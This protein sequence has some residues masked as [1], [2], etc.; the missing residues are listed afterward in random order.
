MRA[1]N[2][3]RALAAEDRFKEGWPL[4]GNPRLGA[5]IPYFGQTLEYQ[6]QTGNGVED[7]T[8][9]IRNFGWAVCFGVV[10]DQV[11]TLCQWKPG[12]N[13]ASWELPPGGIGKIGPEDTLED[14]TEQTKRSYLKETGLGGGNF[15]HL[16]H[17]M[18]ETGKYR[19][20]GP[21]DHGLQ[22]HLFLGTGLERAQGARTP[23]PNEIMETIMVPLEQFPEVLVSGLFMEESAVVCAYKALIELGL[24]KWSK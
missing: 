18:I 10:D 4:V 1:I 14:I 11:A 8:S 23:N 19:G 15:K 3:F 2:Q 7:Y 17:I 22:A 9:I 13:Q 21:D 5:K 6:L 16:G 24:L 12:I 20:A